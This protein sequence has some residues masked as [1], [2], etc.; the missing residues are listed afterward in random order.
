MPG[1]STATPDMSTNNSNSDSATAFGVEETG[2][3]RDWND[4]LQ[5]S[6]SL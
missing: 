3:P 5:V 1:T 4:L 2:P 6:L